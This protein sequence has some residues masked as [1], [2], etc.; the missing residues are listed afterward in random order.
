MKKFVALSAVSILLASMTV[1]AAASPTAAAVV[2]SASAAYVSEGFRTA[3]DQQ[4]A[5]DRG[6]SAGEY[7]NNTVVETTGIENAM[8]VG[9]GGKILIN[10]VATNLTA[11]LSKGNREEVTS[12]SAQAAALGGTLLNVVKID[13][14]NVNYN[15]VTV[16]FYVKGLADGSK[17]A[18]RQYV[19]G[20]WIDV[21]VV[22]IR[23]EHVVLNLKNKGAIAFILL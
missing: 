10:G 13:F 11:T 4:A 8:P 9:Q 16:N 22:E 2:A 14:P 3:A 7:Y 21:E 12:A 19:D 20:A 15:L 23:E 6:M 18:A 5:A 1:N 17:I